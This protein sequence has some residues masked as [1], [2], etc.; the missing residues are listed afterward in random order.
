MS[1]VIH[2]MIK[3]VYEFSDDK[4]NIENIFNIIYEDNA[5]PRILTLFIFLCSI[6]VILSIGAGGKP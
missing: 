1:E 4:T 5:K 6:I 3:R 2:G